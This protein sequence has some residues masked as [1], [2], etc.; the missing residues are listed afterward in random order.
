M[1]SNVAIW[2]EDSPYE[3]A[4]NALHAIEEDVT[5][6]LESW[7]SGRETK[8]KNILIKP[9]LLSTNE[10]YLCNTSVDH[11]LAIADFFHEMGNYKVMVGDGTTYESNKKPS[12]MQALENHGFNAHVEKWSLVDLHD[13]EPGNWFEVANQESSRKI[14]L[15]MAR[16]STDA[17]LVSA[18]KFKTHDVLGLTLAI[19][20]LMGCLNAARYKGEVSF[21]RQGDVKGF[22]HG[23]FDKKP[24]LLTKEQNTGPSKVFLAA[25]IIR[26]A[27]CRLPDVSVIDGSTVMEGKGPRRG[28]ACDELDH[29][30][31][32]S[33]DAVAVDAT[34][35]R[36]AGFSLDSFQYI[37]VAGNVGLGNHLER[38]ITCH[39]MDPREIQVSIKPHPL[40][41]EASPWKDD[42][43][44][45]LASFVNFSQG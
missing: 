4:M 1:P 7:E 35:A 44:R 31:I 32:A 13:D 12:T 8:E 36:I 33:T 9:N 37:R 28:N 38:D 29:L 14:E 25:N 15:A 11:C 23:F 19:K 26:M 6:A 18:A 16:K 45:D 24:H 41:K 3:A 43:M 40:F 2:R 34:C 21:I 30:A 42:E 22:M 27:R 20:N 10:N 17:F 5:N 39:G